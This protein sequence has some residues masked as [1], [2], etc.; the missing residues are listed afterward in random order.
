MN[1]L[2]P[3]RKPLHIGRYKDSFDS[4]RN[5]INSGTDWVVTQGGAAKQTPCN[6]GRGAACFCEANKFL[7]QKIWQ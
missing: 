7:V 1:Y 3:K 6:G 5:E 2:S 4:N